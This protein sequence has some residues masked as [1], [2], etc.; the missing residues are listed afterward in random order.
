MNT[1]NNGGPAFPRP[2]SKGNNYVT[3]EEDVVV[4]PQNGMSLRDWFAGQALIAQM[5][6]HDAALRSGY[7]DEPDKIITHAN[8]AYRFADA[9]LKARKGG[10]V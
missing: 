6:G 2:A 10:A 7:I 5:I 9:M 3:G 8:E 1:I 4:D